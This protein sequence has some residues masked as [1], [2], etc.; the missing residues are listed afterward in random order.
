MCERRME[1]MLVSKSE[2]LTNTTSSNLAFIGN[3]VIFW[4]PSALLL[5]LPF[6]WVYT[7]GEIKASHLEC[8]LQWTVTNLG[9]GEG[10]IVFIS[11][12]SPRFIVYKN[13][14]EAGQQDHVP[15]PLGGRNSPMKLA[16]HLPLVVYHPMCSDSEEGAVDGG[17]VGSLDRTLMKFLTRKH[18]DPMIPPSC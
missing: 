3:K 10:K 5:Y 1:S 11:D 18:L 9:P 13:M 17:E 15:L 6:N 16:L 7:Q 14:N 2:L 4:S 8:Y 12:M